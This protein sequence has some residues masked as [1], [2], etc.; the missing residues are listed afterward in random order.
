MVPLCSD[1]RRTASGLLDLAYTAC[2][3]FD[4]YFE[5][6][7]GPHDTGPGVL[8]IEEAGGRVTDYLGEEYNPFKRDICATN[9]II[10]AAVLKVL[11]RG[12]SGLQR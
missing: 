10:H 4:G 3:R 6:E 5:H 7:L 9:G 12:N 2:G 8:L 1:L 11:Q